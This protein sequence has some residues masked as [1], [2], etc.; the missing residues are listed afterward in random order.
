GVMVADSG[1]NVQGSDANA[2]VSAEAL[3]MLEEHIR[4]AYGSIRYTIGNGCSGGGLQQYMVASMYPGL[5]DGIQPNC[6]F[7]DMWTTAPDVGEFHGIIRYF[8]NNPTEP[9]VHA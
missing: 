3:T 2:S 4:E 7:A 6:S 8:E 9:A 5:L 1:L